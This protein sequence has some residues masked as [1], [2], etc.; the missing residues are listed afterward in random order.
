MPA[1]APDDARCQLLA[2]ALVLSRCLLNHRTDDISKTQHQKQRLCQLQDELKRYAHPIQTQPLAIATI[3]P[4]VRESF[5]KATL[6]MTR[7]RAIGGEQWWGNLPSPTLSQYQPDP[8]PAE[9]LAPGAIAQLCNHFELT[10]EFAAHL[11]ATLDAVDDQITQQQ[12][13]IQAVLAS[14][15]LDPS[16][17]QPEQS[18]QAQ[19]V[20]HLFQTM[21]GAIPIPP[22]ALHWIHTPS[23]I[24]FCLDYQ[25]G[26]LT[27]AHLW[28]ALSSQEQQQIQGFLE[29]LGTFRFDQFDRFPIFGACDPALLDEQWCDRL[30]VTLH[31]SPSE[32]R[33]RL[34]R[35][36]SIIPT[37][38]AEAFLVHDIW[39]HYWQSVLTQ[40]ESDYGILADCWESLRAGEVAYTPQGPLACR[41]LFEVEGTTVRANEERSRLFF[42]GEV[43]QRLG[44]VFTHLIG[45]M[46]ADIA[47]FKFIWDH[48]HAVDQLLSSSLFKAEPAK[49]DLGL[50]D[51]DFLF[52]RVLQPLLELRL[53]VRESSPLE[54]DLLMEWGEAGHPVNTLELQ[55]QLKGAIAQMYQWFLAEYYDHYL[56]TLSGSIG[57]FTQVVS[58]LLYL[59]NAVNTLY[60][61]AIAQ[62]P[63]L[64][65][66]DLLMIFIA[67]Y[68][69]ND[70]YAEFWDVDDV[71]A[72]CFLPCWHQLSEGLNGMVI[73]D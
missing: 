7:Y 49:L 22:G 56:P 42:H 57:M 3:P 26:S 45:E 60:T 31:S 68:C 71:L 17:H 6:L 32:I 8:V 41:D 55:T 24:Y 28:N 23:Q 69:S 53:S 72:T 1:P 12:R 35:S 10:D 20:W 65:F 64:P 62:A 29:S 48:P 67:S 39:G 11:K 15:G 37:A 13:L 25:A 27:D 59:Q 4:S 18:T 33:R 47:E 19:A 36:V 63:Q 58:N 2:E 70:S 73:P 52:L 14:V 43:Q 44:L 66:Q 51:I 54:N 40:F 9:L 61:S 5:V 46:V 16:P 30:S 34:S 50:A 38:K 21:F